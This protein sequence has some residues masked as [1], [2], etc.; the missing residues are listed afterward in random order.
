MHRAPR[1]AC[2]RKADADMVPELIELLLDSEAE[3]ADGA[4]TAL[5]RI[6]GEDFGPAAD[7]VQ[8]DRINAMTKWH[9]WQRTR[10]R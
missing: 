4:S 8:E 6:S 2:I 3:L 5:K 1:L 7:A 9:E 10:V